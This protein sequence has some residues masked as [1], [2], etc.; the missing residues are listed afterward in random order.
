M[1]CMF[2]CFF[3]SLDC[4]HP[5]SEYH[6]EPAIGLLLYIIQNQHMKINILVAFVAVAKLKVY[7]YNIIH[8]KFF[9]YFF[10]I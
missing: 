1:Y 5:H 2:L 10:S 4:L 6:P 3:L 7:L 8:N 9:L